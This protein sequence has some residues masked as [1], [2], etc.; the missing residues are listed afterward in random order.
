MEQAPIKAGGPVDNPEK[1]IRIHFPKALHGGVYANNM[2]VGH[3]REEFVLD[4]LMVAPPAGALTARVITSP[5]HFKRMVKAL[6]ESL[7]Q[8]ENNFGEIVESQPPEGWPQ[9]AIRH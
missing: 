3:T 6:A 2:T 4:F 8:Y 1:E 5:G 9:S 7:E